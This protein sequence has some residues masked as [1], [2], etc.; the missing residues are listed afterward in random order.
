MF[1]FGMML[2]VTTLAIYASTTEKNLNFATMFTYDF[3]N[4]VTLSLVLYTAI[5]FTLLMLTLIVYAWPLFISPDLDN[6]YEWYYPCICKCLRD[7]SKVE[8]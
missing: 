6:P 4:G 5:F 8:D 3:G 2:Q 1:P 7:K